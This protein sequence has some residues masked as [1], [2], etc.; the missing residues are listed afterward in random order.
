MGDDGVAGAVEAIRA[1]HPVLLPTDGVYGL[2]ANAEDEAAVRGL[3]ALKGRDAV[4][5][6]ALIA[7]AVDRLLDALPGLD[8]SSEAIVRALLPGPYT[9]VLRNDE[10]RYPWLAGNRPDTIGVRVAILPDATQRVLDGVGLV[11]ATSANDPGDPAAAS[12][13]EVPA[14]IRAGCGAELDGG[15]LP[16]TA[17]TVIDFSGPEPVV[18]R[19]GAGSAVE[20]LARVGA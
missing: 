4:Q 16:G 20:A 3:Y 13:A 10:R 11:A 12:L 8:S 1:G 15:R 19:H 7:A 6:T 9:L 5:P 18:L 17:S 14:R 2:C